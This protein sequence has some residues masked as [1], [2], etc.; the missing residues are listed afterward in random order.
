MLRKVVY[1]R[2]AVSIVDGGLERM[3]DA[4]PVYALVAGS[5]ETDSL[6]EVD[7]I[8]EDEMSISLSLSTTALMIID[9]EDTSATSR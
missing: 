1:T 7:T 3:E 4:S 5:E 6:A 9:V 2:V 8:E